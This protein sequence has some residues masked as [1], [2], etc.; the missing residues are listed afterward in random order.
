LQ[1]VHDNA[2]QEIVVLEALT[3]S[4]QTIEANQRTGAVLITER[5]RIPLPIRI[6]FGARPDE[7][8]QDLIDSNVVVNVTF[9]MQKLKQLIYALA[10]VTAP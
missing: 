9:D 10:V 1:E 5:L 8:L 4:V 2:V 6:Q 3:D 7:F